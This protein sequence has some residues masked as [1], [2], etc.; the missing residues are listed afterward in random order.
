MCANLSFFE[1]IEDILINLSK[2]DLVFRFSISICHATETG[3]T[4]RRLRA[5]GNTTSWL[6]LRKR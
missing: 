2:L 3:N 1:K 6:L 4:Q 5:L